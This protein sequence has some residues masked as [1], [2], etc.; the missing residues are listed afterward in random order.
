MV[1][2]EHRP[3]RDDELDQHMDRAMDRE[4]RAALLPLPAPSGFAD[5]VL[6]RV[7]EADGPRSIGFC[8]RSGFPAGM[9]WAAAAVLLLAIGLGAVW[10]HQRQRRIEGERMRDQV[11]LALRITGTTIHAMQSQLAQNS[12]NQSQQQETP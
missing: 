9:R 7:Q 6:A 4:L 10:A 1:E 8:S 3:E 2:F 5:R 12:H 11:L